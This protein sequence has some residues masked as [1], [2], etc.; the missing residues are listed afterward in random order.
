MDLALASHGPSKSPKQAR[1]LVQ[2]QRSSSITCKFEK[3]CDVK[4][5][6][7]D[8]IHNKKL[9]K[10]KISFLANYFFIVFLTLLI[11]QF[12]SFNEKSC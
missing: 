7:N 5:N 8:M 12:V 1:K 10:K 11:V 9:K 4:K 6:M 3:L 2:Y